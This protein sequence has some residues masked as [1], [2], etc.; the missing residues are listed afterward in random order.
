ME[1]I[2]FLDVSLLRRKHM[3]SWPPHS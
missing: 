1:N 3:L 2:F